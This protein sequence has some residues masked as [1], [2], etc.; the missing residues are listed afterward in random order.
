MESTRVEIVSYYEESFF[1]PL[2]RH[3]S[4][5]NDRRKLKL[6]SID[7]EFNVDVKN[8]LTSN[9]ILSRS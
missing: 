4:V 1:I 3:I 6:G 7:A 8:G 2:N 5:E 9:P